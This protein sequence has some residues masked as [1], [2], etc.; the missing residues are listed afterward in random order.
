MAYKALSCL[1]TLFM[2]DDDE[3][4]MKKE[5]KDL[6]DSEKGYFQRKKNQLSY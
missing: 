3:K 2:I 1:T 6:S 5:C 4:S